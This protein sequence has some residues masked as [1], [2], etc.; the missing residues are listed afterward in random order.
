MNRLFAVLLDSLKWVGAASVAAM[1]FLTCADVVMRAAGR[2]I[3]GAVELV[4]F[5]AALALACSLPYTHVVRGHVGV[6]MLLRRLPR[7]IQRLVR[8]TTS[9]I[10]ATLFAVI[11]WRTLIYAAELKVSGEV[12]MT[13]EF[14]S[15]L[16]VYFIGFAFA[17]L[18][19]AAL[20]DLA[21]LWTKAVRR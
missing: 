19:L 14:P 6:D 2:P 8:L 15:Y 7:R 5:L 1:M 9:M 11:T 21:G 17:V 12:S 10:A 18:S 4:G 3:T 16:L 13:L 20:K